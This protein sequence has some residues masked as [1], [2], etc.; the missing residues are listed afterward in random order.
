MPITLLRI[1]NLALL[2]ELEWQIGPGLSR[3]PEERWVN[4]D[5]KKQ[6]AVNARM[7]RAVAVRA[8]L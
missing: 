6:T 7:Q 1:K 4:A 8:R 3:S 5:S 2:E